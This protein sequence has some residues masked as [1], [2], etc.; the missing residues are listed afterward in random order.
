M[1]GS[2]LRSPP[3]GVTAIGFHEISSSVPSSKVVRNR[4]TLVRERYT[5]K[6]M[7]RVNLII[8]IPRAPLPSSSLSGP[9]NDLERF[10]AMIKRTVSGL[11]SKRHFS[12][13]QRIWKLVCRVSF[14][15]TRRSGLSRSLLFLP[16]DPRS[17]IRFNLLDRR[18]YYERDRQ[19]RFRSSRHSISIPRQFARRV[20]WIRFY[21]LVSRYGSLITVV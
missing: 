4:A 13:S 21:R 1:D 20:E 10:S 8:P 7:D 12:F 17:R 2:N 18:N 14:A 16:F 9:N 19:F 11:A 3:P 6:L 15:R 5:A